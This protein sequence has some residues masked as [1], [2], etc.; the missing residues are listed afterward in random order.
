MRAVGF[1]SICLVILSISCGKEEGFQNRQDGPLF[2]LVDHNA[3]NVFFKNII[4]E[5]ANFNYLYNP[6]IYLGGGVAIGDINNDDLPDIYVTG[7]MVR[8]ALYLNKG[9]LQFENI[10][11]TSG[12]EGHM[13]RWNMGAT[14]TDVNDDGYMDIYVSVSGPLPDRKNQ[15]FINQGDHTF[16]EEAERYGIAD[17]GFSMQSVFFD[18]DRDGDLDLYV[19]NYPPTPFQSSSAYYAEKMEN[20][21]SEETDRMY[22]NEGGFFKDVTQES[23]ILNFG[24][25]LGVSVSDFNNDGWPDIYVSNDFNS[26]DYLYINMQ[27]GTFSNQLK[28]YT[29]HTSQFGMGTD[30]ADINNDGLI[31]LMQLDMSAS[32]NEQQKSNMSAMRPDKF[33]EHVA[34]GLHHQYMKNTLQ[35]NTGLNSFSEIAE[36]TGMANTD[37]S[38]GPLIFDMDNDG[39]KDVFIT[40]GIRR[41]VNDNDFRKLA[42]KVAANSVITPEKSLELLNKMPIFPVDN[43]VYL[44]NGDLT[45]NH[46][47]NNYGLSYKGFS[48]GAS[49][50]DLDNDGDLDVVINNL[51]DYVKIFENLS[52][53]EEDRNFLK[54]R[55]KAEGSNVFGLG[56]KVKVF[57]DEKMQMQELMATR[58]Y[59]SSVDPVVHFGLGNE[60]KIDSL[61]VTWPDGARQVLYETAINTTVEIEQNPSSEKTRDKTVS[62]NPLF[63]V[64]DINLNPAYRHVENEFNDFERELLLPH[65]MSQFGPALAVADVNLDGLDDFYVGGALGHSGG[66]YVQDRSGTF[67]V[68]NSSVWKSDGNYED[69]HALFFDANGDSLPDL[70]IVSG[71][72]ENPEGHENYRDRM[73]RNLGGGRFQKIPNALP[74]ITSSGSRVVSADYDN[75]GDLDL[76][77]GGRQIPGKYPMPTDSYLL[78]NIGTGDEILF[79]NVTE[80]KAA[81]LKGI[82]MVTD[83]V[84][85][86]VDMDGRKDL[87]IVGEW[88]APTILR[89]QGDSLEPVLDK[90]H[91]KKEIGWWNTIVATD[92]DDDGDD[93][94]ILGNLGLN[95]KYKATADEPFNVYLNDF[96]DNGQL[97]I[98]LG[99]YNQGGLFPLRGR[100]CSSEQVPGIKK[101]FMDYR[102]FANASLVEVYSQEALSGSL[103]YGAT[104]FSHSVIIN[105]RDSISI[106]PLPNYAQM[107]SV[108][109]IVAKDFDGDANI[110]LAL[111][112]NLF[113]SEVETPRNDASY[114][115]FLGGNPDGSFVPRTPSASGLKV[116]GEIRQSLPIKVGGKNC[117]LLARNEDTLTVLAY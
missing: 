69:V 24:L 12:T 51:N 17:E 73:Y 102:S 84:W 80:E 111:F 103:H 14:M 61:E 21:G 7:N 59:L 47:P 9:N 16:K 68:S 41:N 10:S 5:T 98:V 66:L 100:E 64:V 107:S 85:S 76:F 117:L 101:K 32:T 95:Y 87:I 11:K 20:P 92:I 3:S 34:L 44:N 4:T 50:G 96:D 114:G 113:Q 48:N 89:N 104:N 52:E 43:Y 94:Y 60:K 88:M 93:D 54:I 31:D 26:M 46:S 37:W 90:Y 2:A 15:L 35:L 18:Y 45:F 6:Y 56:A 33:H 72:S 49:Y 1:F 74:E 110:D 97:D 77:V 62:S 23:G 91:L 57:Y 83:A 82:G 65:K 105:H 38:W 116:K 36:L 67:T 19:A 8:N 99:Y 106:K 86:D 55:L 108:N 27:N 42:Q 53:K 109:S 63:E 112:G 22:R 29:M 81:A 39:L 75:D 79:K 115:L 25:T 28:D 58:G 30:A 71:G 40:N 13:P 70:Y 78:E